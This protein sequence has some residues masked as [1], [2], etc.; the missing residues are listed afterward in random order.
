MPDEQ[1]PRPGAGDSQRSGG[2]P[3]PPAGGSGGDRSGP[4][5]QKPPPPR[6][7]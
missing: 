7:P 1:T 5:D 6:R 2:D 4:G 3:K